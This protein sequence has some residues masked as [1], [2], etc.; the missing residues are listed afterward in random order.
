MASF[1]THF[2]T[3]RKSKLVA[4]LTFLQLDEPVQVFELRDGPTCGHELLLVASQVLRP[5]RFESTAN[6]LLFHVAT[7]YRRPFFSFTGFLARIRSIGVPPST[8]KF[9]ASI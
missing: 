6:Y 7:S 5:V 8:G 4:N 2:Q 3:K 1:I 9:E